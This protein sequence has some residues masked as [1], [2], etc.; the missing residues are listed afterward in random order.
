MRSALGLL[1][2]FPKVIKSAIL[3]PDLLVILEILLK[4]YDIFAIA[5]SLALGLAVCRHDLGL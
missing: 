5:V 4:L 2:P 1:I 3:P